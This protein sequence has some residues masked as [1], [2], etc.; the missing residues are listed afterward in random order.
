[1]TVK[2]LQTVQRSHLVMSVQT[3]PT[4]LHKFKSGFVDCAEE[5]NRVIASM[6]N[7]DVPSKQRLITHLNGCITGLQQVA[8][9]QFSGT[10]FGSNNVSLNPTIHQTPQTIPIP[11]QDVNNNSGRIQMGGVQFIPSRLPTGELALVMPNST[12]LQYFPQSTFPQQQQQI[13]LNTNYQRPSAF[14]TVSKN[15][16]RSIITSPPLSPISSISSCGE[17]S[18]SEFHPIIQTP[19]LQQMNHHNFINT[20]PTPPSTNTSF[21]IPSSSLQQS[22]ISS[23]TEIMSQQQFTGSIIKPDIHYVNKKRPYPVDL[24]EVNV[25]KPSA[26][27]IVKLEVPV[28]HQLENQ[29]NHEDGQDNM[30]RPW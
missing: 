18:S 14:N 28:A 21:K 4:V 29:E 23:T 1:M 27:K 2:H 22:H 24:S 13:D 9:F 25:L 12:N 10:Q 26:E 3:D 17:D 15:G 6:D 30:W 20:F 19:P 11:T 5:V 7:V 16:L 8:P